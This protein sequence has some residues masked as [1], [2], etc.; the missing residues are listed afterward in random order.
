MSQFSNQFNITNEK[1]ALTLV[2]NNNV[3]DALIAA[4]AV[5]PLE[6]GMAVSIKDVSG[7]IRVEEATAL[8]S[9]IFGFVPFDVVTNSRGADEA[10]KVAFNDC[11]MVMEASEA[12]A[13]GAAVQFDPSTKK[14]SALVEGNTKIGYVLGKTAADGDLV[15]VLIKTPG[16]FSSIDVSESIEAAGAVSAENKL[17]TLDLPGAG[18]VTLAAPDASMIGQ[19]KVIE[20][21]TDNGDVT[22]ALTEVQGGSAAATCT[23]ANVG[24]ALV[25]VASSTKWNVVSEG[26]VVLS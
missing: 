18:A 24:D 14:I 2:L 19:V 10:I 15:N 5:T 16:S 9:D 21:T 11:V 8:D 22:L 6:A 4:D 23:W 12:I 25:L 1:G 7:K 13:S 17:S 20:M 3:I 26:G